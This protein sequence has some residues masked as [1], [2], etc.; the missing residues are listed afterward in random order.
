MSQRKVLKHR[1]YSS[2]SSV[3]FFLFVFKCPMTKLPQHVF[4][5][6]VEASRVSEHRFSLHC[7]FRNNPLS[8]LISSTKRSTLKLKKGQSPW[9]CSRAV[10]GCGCGPLSEP[11]RGLRLWVC[12][13]LC[14][15]WGMG[16]GSVR[17][18]RTTCHLNAHIRS[19]THS[20]TQT[21]NNRF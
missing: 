4:V 14:R 21:A 5:S 3:V 16:F 12:Q 6:H 20:R 13:L 11:P 10:I 15:R 17:K 18:S 19:R 2:D 9:W 1:R 8:S 7:F